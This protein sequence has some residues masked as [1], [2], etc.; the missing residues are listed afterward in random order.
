MS[1]VVNGCPEREN[2]D[3]EYEKAIA[4]KKD[5]AVGN[6]LQQMRTRKEKTY[7]ARSFKT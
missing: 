5:R 6:S 4:G 2:R 1:S 3:K 7:E